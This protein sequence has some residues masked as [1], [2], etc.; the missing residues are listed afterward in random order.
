M[1]LNLTVKGVVFQMN[2]LS[3]ADL[4]VGFLISYV[5][6]SFTL[7]DDFLTESP[8]WDMSFCWASDLL[9]PFVFHVW[10]LVFLSENMLL[11]NLLSG[12][13]IS[14]GCC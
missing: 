1:N 3:G 5:G 11:M 6:V 14:G 7:S 13:G 9:T 12:A 2:F 10:I 8:L 4:C